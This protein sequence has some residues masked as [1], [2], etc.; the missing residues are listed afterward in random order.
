MYP[1]SNAENIQSRM[2][3]GVKQNIEKQGEKSVPY[4]HNQ[5]TKGLDMWEKTH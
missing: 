3:Y 2:L 5:K 1:A 4:F